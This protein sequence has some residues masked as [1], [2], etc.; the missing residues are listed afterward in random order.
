[1]KRRIRPR[2]GRHAPIEIRGTLILKYQI[3][4][5]VFYWPFARRLSEAIASDG[6][7]AR[8]GSAI[9]G[10]S[11]ARRVHWL[12]ATAGACGLPKP[13]QPV[14][15]RARGRASARSRPRRLL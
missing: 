11:Y 15:R 5:Q 7:C 13:F 6:E 9:R 1:M 4:W 10:G 14:G 8:R 2:L 3:A 12:F